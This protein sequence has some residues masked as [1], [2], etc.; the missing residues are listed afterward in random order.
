MAWRIDQQVIRGELDSRTKGQVTGT[1]WLAG[2]SEPLRLRLEGDPWRDW[3]GC[4][5]RFSNRSPGDEEGDLSGLATE[6][7]G[8]C[9]DMTVSRKV[10]TP[11]EPVKEWLA[12]GAPGKD[13]LP[14]SNSIYL[15][16]FSDRNGRVVIELTRYALELS[17]PAWSMTEYEEL[18]QRKRNFGEMQDFM[19][20]LQDALKEAAAEDCL[21]SGDSEDECSE[22]ELD[23]EERESDRTLDLIF[24]IEELKRKARGL[25]GGQMITGQ[26]SGAVPLEAE[27]QFWK[28]VLDFES[29]PSK[30]WCEILAED[31]F[32]ARPPETLSDDELPAHLWLLIEALAK[33]RAFLLHT[34][35]LSDR[36]LYCLLVNEVLNEETELLPPEA[37]WNCN[38][39]IDEYSPEGEDPS[40][41]FLRYYAD[42]KTRAG[43][44]SDLGIELPRHMDPPYNRDRHLPGQG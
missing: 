14:W 8:A 24:E 33:R 10:R 15:E 12:Q 13:N 38:I 31:G 7:K 42:K 2:R 20:R 21:R 4:H 16:W 25:G 36:E 34:N 29:A 43:W 9:G 18:E 39:C 22:A 30:P 11:P 28:H 37:E 40:M 23:A 41:V 26:P 19:I 6:Q 17:E 1:I 35:H 27:H 32:Q 3:A 44:A 5:L